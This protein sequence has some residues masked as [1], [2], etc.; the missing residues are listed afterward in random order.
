VRAQSAISLGQG[1][2]HVKRCP[3][4]SF[5][6]MTFAI[7]WGL[8]AL[9]FIFPNFLTSLLGPVSVSNPLFVLAVWAPTISGFILSAVTSGGRGVLALLK[10]FLPGRASVWWYVVTVLMIPVAGMLIVLAARGSIP[11]LTAAPATLLSFLFINLITGPLGEEF[12]WRGFALPRLLERFQPLLAAVILGAIWGAWHLPSFMMAGTPQSGL[13]L[14]YFLLSALCL[15]V[16]ITWV[17]IHVRQSIFFGFL[18]HYMINFTLNLTGTSLLQL[19]LLLT[20]IA[21]LVVVFFGWDLG[22]SKVP[23]Q[24]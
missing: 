18:F 15:S 12:G 24:R 4:L 8:A 11:L 23:I 21:I 1:G 6:I 14:P 19:S 16:I 10:R 9:Y 5:F 20:A 13:Q 17:F 22:K 2:D 7:T 3:L